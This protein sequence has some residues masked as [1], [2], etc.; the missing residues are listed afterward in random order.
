M[1]GT[2]K[3]RYEKQQVACV[4]GK[5]Q[6]EHSKRGTETNGIITQTN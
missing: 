3:M 1:D 6:K 4:V 5:Q 2:E